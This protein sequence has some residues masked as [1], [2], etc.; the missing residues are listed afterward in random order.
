MG[1][2]KKRFDM[3]VAP[4]DEESLKAW[5]WC[6]RNNI[7]IYPTCANEKSWWLSIENKG[8]THKDP[9][10]YGKNEIWDKLYEYCKYYFNKYNK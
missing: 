9:K 3:G 8:K 4:H 7:K 2:T 10:V 5:R 1:V 6:I